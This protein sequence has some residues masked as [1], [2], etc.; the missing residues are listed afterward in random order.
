MNKTPK[1]SP[2]HSNTVNIKKD[3][4]NVIIPRNLSD[5]L[6]LNKC[7]EAKAI[8]G[9]DIDSLNPKTPQKCK[10]KVLLSKSLSDTD[11]ITEN[12]PEKEYVK[13]N[14]KIKYNDL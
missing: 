13:A 5:P 14:Y 2:L 3:Q 11:I 6:E 8:E 10:P 9:S 1:S 7:D 4:V 12:T